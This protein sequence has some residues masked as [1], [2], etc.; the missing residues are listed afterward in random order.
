MN[1]DTST[2]VSG[3]NAAT[4]RTSRRY[5][6]AQTLILIGFAALSFLTPKTYLFVLPVAHLVGNG[7]CALGILLMAPALIALRGTIQI[8]PEPKSGRQLVD[9][10]VYKYL[11]HPIYTGIVVCVAG[12]FLRQPSVWMAGGA[13]VVIV[14]LACK[15]RFE[16]KLLRAVYPGYAAYQRRSWGLFPGLYR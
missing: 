6:L 15:V 5:G 7:F 13:M 8:D 4:Q 16:E 12:L 10:G 1:P 2:P 14:F 9:T 3:L 11:R